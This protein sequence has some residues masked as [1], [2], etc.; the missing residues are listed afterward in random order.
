MENECLTSV[1]LNLTVVELAVW[2]LTVDDIEAVGGPNTHAAHLKVEPL[3]VMI[4]VDVWIQHKVI[5]VSKEI[6]HDLKYQPSATWTQ[7]ILHWDCTAGETEWK[8]STALNTTVIKADLSRIVHLIDEEYKYLLP[9][10]NCLPEVT[11]LKLRVELQRFTIIFNHWTTEACKKK[12]RQYL[13]ETNE[14]SL[15]I[16]K[17]QMIL[18][19]KP[20]IYQWLITEAPADLWRR[21][22]LG[23][24]RS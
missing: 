18:W 14:N 5:L 12:K 7:Y 23:T 10:L 6:P 9:N 21:T 13:R 11:R 4:T 1:V 3:V 19:P 8:L 17:I 20:L 16:L 15:F 24:S 22:H 2:L